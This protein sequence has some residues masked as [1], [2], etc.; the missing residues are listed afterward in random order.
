MDWIDHFGGKSKRIGESRKLLFK[1]LN[2]NFDSELSFTFEINNVE[3][4]SS[5][6]NSYWYRRGNLTFENPKLDLSSVNESIQCEI[7]EQLINELNTLRETVYSIFEKKTSLGRRSKANVDKLTVL[8]LARELKIDIPKTS[9]SIE[10][11]FLRKML[12]NDSALITK[13]I[14]ANLGIY[15]N[16]FEEDVVAWLT[17]TEELNKEDVNGKVRV[18]PSLVQEKLDKKIELRI[19]YLDGEFYTMAIFSQLDEQTSIDFRKYNFVKPNRMVPYK[20][21]LNISKKLFKLM[22]KLDLD[23][24]SIDMVVTK[25]N[26]YVFLEVNPAGQFGMVSGPCNYKLEKKIAQLLNQK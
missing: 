24:G 9:V 12:S 7:K 19:F 2:L 15:N 21:P 1:N 6:F 20:L 13:S 18:F 17:H 3:Y 14:S 11:E 16:D 8:I 4:C 25:D 22:E 23:T 26:R 10:P 5:D